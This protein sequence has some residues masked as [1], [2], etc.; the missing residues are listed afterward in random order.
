MIN[1]TAG[2]DVRRDG[3][4]CIDKIIAAMRMDALINDTIKGT[5]LLVAALIQIFI[6]MLRGR[7]GK[8]RE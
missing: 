4:T 7:M 1:L 5:I 8:Q 3:C 2:H 6:P